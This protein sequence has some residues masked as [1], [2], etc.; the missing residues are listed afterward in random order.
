MRSSAAIDLS[1]H[2]DVLFDSESV[3]SG[4]FIVRNSLCPLNAKYVISE[5][6]VVF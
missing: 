6:R 4:A 1:T 5:L 2:S 3:G